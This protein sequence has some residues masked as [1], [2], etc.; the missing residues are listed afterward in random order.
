MSEA[1]STANPRAREKQIAEAFLAGFP[2]PM[3]I[4]PLVNTTLWLALWPLVLN[5]ILPLWAGFAIALVNVTASYLPSHDAQH[6]IFFARES[7]FHWLNELIG[8]YSLIPLALPLCTLRETHLEH[9]RHANVP[10]LDPDYHIMEAPDA[11]TALWNALTKNQ[12]R[13]DR[14]GPAL[15]RLGTPLAKRAILEALT[16]KAAFFGILSA[17]AW[18]GHAAEAVLLWW[19][20]RHIAL[21]YVNFYLSWMPHFPGSGQG[22]YRDTRAFRSK[23]GNVGS[24]GMQY[25]LIHHLYPTIPLYRTPAAYRALRPILE[26]RGCDL[27]GL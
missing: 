11:R 15:E 20:P 24:S 3:L 12:P 17:L 14:Y 16:A 9:H 21:V 6:H 27:G 26:Q 2:W 4:W 25:H 13:Y 23:L 1:Q 18:T 19:L 8:Y 5:G 10:A 7:R 22:R